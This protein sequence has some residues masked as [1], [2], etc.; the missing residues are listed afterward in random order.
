MKIILNNLSNDVINN[1]VIN[2][3]KIFKDIKLLVVVC[4]FGCLNIVKEL[5]KVGVDVNLKVVFEILLI[6][7]C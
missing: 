5:L 1:I 3:E 7:V 2:E 4:L 6:V